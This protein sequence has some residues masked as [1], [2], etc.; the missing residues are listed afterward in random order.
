MIIL[1]A[2]NTKLNMVGTARIY[3]DHVWSKHGLPIKIISDQGPQFVAQFM[4]DLHVLFGIKANPSMTYHPQT[5]GQT[6][7]MN[8]EVEQYLHLFINYESSN[9][10]L[11]LVLLTRAF[12][13]LSAA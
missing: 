8:Q 5:D 9:V 11:R 6:E 2:T 7:Q 13:Q 1:I 4:K 10:N 12:K 3:R